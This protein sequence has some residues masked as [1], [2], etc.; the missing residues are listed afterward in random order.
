MYRLRGA[1]V[2]GVAGVAALALAACGPL[3]SSAAKDPTGATGATVTAT[4]AASSTPR[5]PLS[6]AAHAITALDLV[7]KTAS[8]VHSAKVD[9]S[10]WAG[11]IRVTSS[12]GTLDWGHGLTGTAVVSYTAGQAAEQM[13]AAGL[14]AAMQV[15]YLP[16][17]FYVNMGPALAAH[18]GGRHWVKYPLAT[19]GTIAGGT[20]SMLKNAAENGNPV[21]SIQAALAAPGIRDLGPASVRGVQARHYRGVVDLQAVGRS[22]S[23]DLT[24]GEQAE[25]RKSLTS[26]GATKETVDLWVSADNLPVEAQILVDTAQGEVKTLTYYADFGTTVTASA[27][28]AF[29]TVDVTE[30]MDE[31]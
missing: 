12:V 29:D 9:T 13:S 1:A 30:L 11:G 19:L 21:K 4:A 5:S 23:I 17:A 22:S 27:P 16:E 2:T 14:P 26:I 8:G 10:V 7:K 28:S 31:E 6:G 20:G 3:G 24:A 25:V 18:V 15:R